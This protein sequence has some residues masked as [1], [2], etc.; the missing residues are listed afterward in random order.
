MTYKYILTSRSEVTTTSLRH[1]SSL[2]WVTSDFF[3]CLR[4]MYYYEFDVTLKDL[5][6]NFF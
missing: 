4:S 5:E 1:F 2:F 6:T 3:K